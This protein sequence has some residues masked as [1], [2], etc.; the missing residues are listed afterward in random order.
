[1]ISYKLDRFTR[2]ADDY[3]YLVKAFKNIEVIFSSLSYT[4]KKTPIL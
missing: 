4:S 2:N 3:A 1:M